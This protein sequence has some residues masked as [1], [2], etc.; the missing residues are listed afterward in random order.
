MIDIKD[1]S[2]ECNPFAADEVIYILFKK[3]DE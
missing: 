2:L 1:N 3:F